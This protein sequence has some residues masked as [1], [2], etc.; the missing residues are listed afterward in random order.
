MVLGYVFWESNVE[1]EM[2][3]AVLNFALGIDA[4]IDERFFIICR[5]VVTR[6]H[7]IGAFVTLKQEMV[8]FIQ[9][10]EDL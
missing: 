9:K 6:C 2:T 3:A 5:L 1:Q 7:F 4:A 10:C 8:Y